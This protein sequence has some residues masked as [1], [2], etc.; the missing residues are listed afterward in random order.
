MGRDQNLREL[1]VT[2]ILR[3]TIFVNREICEWRQFS[4]FFVI[5]SEEIEKWCSMISREIARTRFHVLDLKWNMIPWNAKNFFW[6]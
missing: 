3:F 1:S 6:T 4:L 5:L 2:V